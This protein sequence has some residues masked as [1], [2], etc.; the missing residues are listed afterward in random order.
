VGAIDYSSWVLL[1]FGV[2][3]GASAALDSICQITACERYIRWRRWSSLTPR[4]TI[5][6]DCNATRHKP[7]SIARSRSRV[8]LRPNRGLV[9]LL[10]LSASP[11]T[12]QSVHPRLTILGRL[13]RPTFP[14]SAPPSTGTGRLV[15]SMATMVKPH[16]NIYGDR[17][18]LVHSMGTL[19]SM[20]TGRLID[21]VYAFTGTGQFCRAGKWMRLALSMGSGRFWAEFGRNRSIMWAAAMDAAGMNPRTLALFGTGP[22]RKSELIKNLN[23]KHETR[24]A[25]QT[26]CKRL[27]LGARN[28]PHRAH[29]R[30]WQGETDLNAGQ[31]GKGTTATGETPMLF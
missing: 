27:G 14:H 3:R 19:S 8:R 12:K 2:F 5:G 7:I 29:G 24:S 17:S 15:D 28:S 21:S 18:I 30:R 31:S 6:K 22:I 26:L 20:G 23:V 13:V 10:T 25:V 1:F 11:L 4:R 9:A 16:S